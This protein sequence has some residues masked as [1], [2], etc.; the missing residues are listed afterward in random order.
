MITFGPICEMDSPMIAL[1]IAADPWHRNKPSIL[2]FF[3]SPRCLMFEDTKG[4]VF[5]VRFEDNGKVVTIHIQFG[6]VS[7]FRTA[8]ALIEGFQKILPALEDAGYSEF[9]FESDNPSLTAFC[10]KLGFQTR[11]GL[12]CYS[13][14]SANPAATPTPL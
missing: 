14:A 8:K 5:V 2:Q 4:P 12:Q 6:N 9:R 3:T 13:L 11:N 7:K 1:W 10:K